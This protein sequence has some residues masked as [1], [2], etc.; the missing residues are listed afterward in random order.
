MVRCLGGLGF[1]GGIGSLVVDGL[2]SRGLCGVG[3]R[4]YFHRDGMLVACVFGH[5]LIKLCVVAVC[6]LW[7]AW[8]RFQIKGLVCSLQL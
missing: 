6:W 3:F 2:A 4:N 8:T 5:V 1:F 7:F